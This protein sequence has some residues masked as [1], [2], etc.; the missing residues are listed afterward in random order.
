MSFY[1]FNS[2]FGINNNINIGTNSL[3]RY[4]INSGNFWLLGCSFFFIVSNDN[5]GVYKVLNSSVLSLIDECLFYHCGTTIGSGG[6][7]YINPIDKITGTVLNKIC[8]IKTYAENS[9]FCLITSKNYY[10]NYI[11]LTSITSIN[12]STYRNLLLNNGNQNVTST[13][14]SNSITYEPSS[15]T[16]S[17]PNFNV[18]KFVTISNCYSINYITLWLHGG[19][20]NSI[21][22]SNFI[23]NNQLSNLFGIIYTRSNS[24]CYFKFCI[25]YKNTHDLFSMAEN[26]YF[27]IYHC[28][29]DSYS[30]NKHC[31]ISSCLNI[32]DFINTFSITSTFLLSHYSTNLCF[33]ENPITKRN[34]Y[35]ISIKNKKKFSITILLIFNLI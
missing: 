29:S 26:G 3:N 6:A 22:Y 35:L 32:I 13:N 34:L 5:G 25:F 11:L 16:S 24:K 15:L 30:Y 10:P 28:W 21:F 31:W 1:E 33:A 4:E 9:A 23:N 19:N 12:T 27:L 2:Y 7:I 17:S 8:G 18:I 20:N 14:I